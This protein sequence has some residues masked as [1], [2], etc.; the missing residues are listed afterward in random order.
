[1]NVTGLEQ[2]HQCKSNDETDSGPFQATQSSLQHPAQTLTQARATL[3]RTCGLC[4]HVP[5]ARQTR[6]YETKLEQNRQAQ[7]S[8]TAK[9][10]GPYFLS[11]SD[12]YAS[13]P[14]FFISSTG[15]K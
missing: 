13:Y 14:L 15:M 2:F 3:K 6:C 1:M 7:T 9:E 5:V 8:A 4:Q 11:K 12:R 10:V